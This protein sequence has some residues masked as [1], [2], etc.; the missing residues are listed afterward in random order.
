MLFVWIKNLDNNFADN[1]KNENLKQIF[2]HHS[3]WENRKYFQSR[4][5]E[6][7]KKVYTF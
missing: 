1:Y 6:E 3:N 4:H 5:I 2:V 7:Q